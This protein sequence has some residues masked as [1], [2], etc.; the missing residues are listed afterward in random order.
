MA[1]ALR[2]YQSVERF[3]AFSVLA[4]GCRQLAQTCMTDGAKTMLRALADDLDQQVSGTASLGA[5]VQSGF[6]DAQ[7]APP[8]YG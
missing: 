3:E 2:G 6:T 5:I 7:P 8:V 4:S 1:S